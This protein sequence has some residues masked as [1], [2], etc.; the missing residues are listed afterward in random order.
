[1]NMKKQFKNYFIPHKENDHKPHMVREVSVIIL[2]LIAI[3]AFAGSTLQS[4]LLQQ[5]TE[6]LAAVLPSVLVELTNEDRT[7]SD[8]PPLQTSPVLQAAAQMKAND[9]AEK[10]YF[11][12]DDPEGRSPWYWFIQAG[13]QFIYAGENLAVNF[14]DSKEVEDAWMRSPGHRSNILGSNFTEVGI[15]TA[16]G[17]YEGKKTIFVVQL[18]GTPATIAAQP[19]PAQESVDEEFAEAVSG[20]VA[21]TES[22][23]DEEPEMAEEP[24]EITEQEPT[25]ESEAEAEQERFEVV[26]EDGLFIS[27][28]DTQNLSE[29]T[30]EVET[31]VATDTPTST[32]AGTEAPGLV[33]PQEE[34][35]FWQKLATQPRTLLAWL[36][37]VFGAILLFV[38]TAM[39]L[40]EIEKQHPRNVI[41]GL[42]L[43]ALLMVLIYISRNIIFGEL[44]IV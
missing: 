24:E 5:N 23:V 40:I 11:A 44:I 8:L 12:H 27:V 7:E 37:V 35:S 15:A 22:G 32:V 9:M 1:M 4:Y 20:E 42:F 17:T 16:E 31:D 14:V 6:Y 30:E 2:A 38:L 39:V 43:L 3:A 33:S 34:I 13:Y 21:G 19:T 18:F 29:E 25:P 41:Y 10:G 28:Q 26:E 36:Y